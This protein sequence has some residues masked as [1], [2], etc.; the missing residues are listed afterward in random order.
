VFDSVRNFFRTWAMAGSYDRPQANRSPLSPFWYLSPDE[1]RNAFRKTRSGVEVTEHTALNYS[2]F[3][4]A[5]G[6]ICDTLGTLPR[7]FYS[8]TSGGVK[9]PAQDHSAAYVWDSEPNP[10]MDGITFHS[11]Q[12]FNLVNHGN[13]YALKELEEPG[14]RIKHLWPIHPTRVLKVWMENGKKYYEVQIKDVGSPKAYAAEEIFHVVGRFS[15]DGLTGRGVLTC[16]AESIGVGIAA[17]RFAATYYGNGLHRGVYIKVDGSLSPDAYKRMKEDWE[18]KGGLENAHKP[19][20]LEAGGEVKQL[21]IPAD[22]VQL[23][24]ARNFNP[25]EIARWFN[26]PLHLLRIQMEKSGE[27][28]DQEN[29]HFKIMT[30]QPWAVRYETAFRYQCLGRKDRYRYVALFDF[31]ALMRADSLTRSQEDRERWAV[32]D[33]TV[34]E[35]RIRDGRNPIGK[36]G[37]VRF[38]PENMITIEGALQKAE[39]NRMQAEASVKAAETKAAAPND[40]KLDPA[41]A[42]DGEKPNPTKMSAGLKAAVQII[43]RGVADDI[44][45]LERQTVRAYF[46]AADPTKIA[47]FPKNLVPHLYLKT[48]PDYSVGCVTRRMAPLLAEGVKFPPHFIESVIDPFLKLRQTAVEACYD[49]PVS[50]LPDAV[51]SVMGHDG[52]EEFFQL[53]S[54]WLDSRD[55]DDVADGKHLGRA[56]RLLV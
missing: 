4:A 14:G 43:L 5:N 11:M 24:Q 30:L 54:D 41:N 55:P 3:W 27:A 47:A 31:D 26:V 13:C 9:V 44:V 42:P 37:D 32:G 22:Q 12:L 10:C 52:R 34:N 40:N 19:L 6:L 2:A 53:A 21:M 51:L 39:L 18:Q 20:I 16:A 45:S 46:E 17:D 50:E 38:V 35:M 36:D 23:L 28:T 56:G 29:K 48:L 49:Q 33:R 1:I 25:T 15:K 8:V 7:K